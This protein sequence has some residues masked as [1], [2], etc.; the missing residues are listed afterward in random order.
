MNAT[1]THL[2]T[3]KFPGSQEKSVT[4][5]SVLHSC[6]QGS[7]TQWW[8]RKT[9]DSLH[10]IL[11]YSFIMFK[12]SIRPSKFWT[13]I[14]DKLFDFHSMFRQK[15][16]YQTKT[17]QSSGGY[18]TLPQQKAREAK[19]SLMPKILNNIELTMRHIQMFPAGKSGAYCLSAKRF[20]I[21]P[22]SQ[23]F[24]PTS[25]CSSSAK[26]QNK[27]KTF[28]RYILPIT[29]IYIYTWKKNPAHSPWRWQGEMRR[30]NIG[31]R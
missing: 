19:A 28:C 6:T 25:S 16:F 4:H 17:F 18:V 15:G 27:V 22:S 11:F 7:R 21:P 5:C 1:F 14:Q 2:I 26:H 9:W 24:Y 23:V 12:T 3:H 30:F 8:K 10:F 20:P 29:Y 31:Q 13:A